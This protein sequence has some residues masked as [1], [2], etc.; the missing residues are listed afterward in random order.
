M[1]IPTI[2][3]I[4][5]LASTITSPTPSQT[6]QV[7]SVVT[8]CTK[9]KLEKINSPEEFKVGE[10]KI[11]PPRLIHSMYSNIDSGFRCHFYSVDNEI[12]WQS[13]QNEDLSYTAYVIQKDGSYKKYDGAII[14]IPDEEIAV[15]RDTGRQETLIVP[16]HIVDPKDMSH[17]I[18]TGL[19]TFKLSQES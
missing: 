5:V 6:P 13:Q 15:R 17:I 2:L 18:D 3:L 16:L 1:T 10:R 14:I 11:R 7:V 12:L 9:A 8:D 4:A 19:F